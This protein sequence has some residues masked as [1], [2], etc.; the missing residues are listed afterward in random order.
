MIPLGK[1]AFSLSF[2]FLA[3]SP[4]AVEPAWSRSAFK[5]RGAWADEHIDTLPSKIRTRVKLFQRNCG[6]RI[7]ATQFFARPVSSGRFLVLHYEALWCPKP[8]L[9]CRKETC[10]HEVYVQSSRGFARVFSGF[11]DDET[12]FRGRSGLKLNLMEE[13]QWDGKRFL[14]L[15]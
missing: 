4:V 2:G 1:F 8:D 12:L 11:I 13:L 6:D 14:P 9:V 10:L 3:I 5:E 15:Q 7:A